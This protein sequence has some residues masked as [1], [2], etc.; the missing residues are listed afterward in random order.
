MRLMLTIPVLILALACASRDSQL[1]KREAESDIK[2]DYPVAVMLRVPNST[3]AEKGSEK[4]TKLVNTAEAL[5][6]NG[7]FVVFRTPEGGSRERFEFKLL[8]AAPKSILTAPKG[9]EIPAAQA[10]FVKAVRMEP[11]RDGAK[12]TY[13]IRLSKPTEQFEL[14]AKLHGARI[15]GTAERHAIYRREGRKWILQNTDE[16]YQ[17]QD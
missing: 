1:S 12:V 2:K 7:W 11:T 3:T 17:K 14:Y 16:V 13:Q 4:F 5:T 8:P 10:E 6:Q 9:Y 15:G